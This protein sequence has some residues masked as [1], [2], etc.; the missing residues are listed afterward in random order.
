M[1]VKEYMFAHLTKKHEVIAC[2]AIQANSYKEA[3]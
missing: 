1:E 2:Y 3:L